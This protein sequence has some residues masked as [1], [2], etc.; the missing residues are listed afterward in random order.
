LGERGTRGP[1]VSVFEALLLIVPALLIPPF[2]VLALARCGA[3]V[4]GLRWK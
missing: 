4:I 3:R 1:K 2:A